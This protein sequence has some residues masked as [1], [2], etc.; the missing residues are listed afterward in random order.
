ME[1]PVRGT[2]VTLP[3]GEGLS[4]VVVDVLPQE[5]L[6]GLYLVCST[7]L[8]QR[9]RPVEYSNG[10]S[11]DRGDPGGSLDARRGLR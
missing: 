1:D 4:G 3:A 5:G 10:V 8:L 9:P 7:A 6:V 11:H 2:W